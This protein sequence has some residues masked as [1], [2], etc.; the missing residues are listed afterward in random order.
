MSDPANQDSDSVQTKNNPTNDYV[1]WHDQEVSGHKRMQW[2]R[3]T[4]SDPSNQ[5]NDTDHDVSDPGYQYSGNDKE[6]RDST[7]RYSDSHHIMVTV[8][9]D[10]M[11][12]IKTLLT[13][14]AIQTQGRGRGAK[15][16]KPPSSFG[17][18]GSDE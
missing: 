8:P 12:A 7:N 3:S 13:L 15:K 1:R 18:T 17:L 14:P 6:M 4:H 9:I 11:I 10:A 2:Q 5:Y 16:T